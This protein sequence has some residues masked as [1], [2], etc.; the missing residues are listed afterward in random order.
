MP[1]YFS[2]ISSHQTQGN[3]MEDLKSQ[4]PIV[5]EQPL[6]WNDMDSYQHI[7]NTVYFR[8]FEDAR[9]AYFE[10]IGVNEYK[11]QHEVGP[12]LASTRCDFR[13]PL[14]FPDTIRITATVSEIKEKRFTMHYQVFSLKHEAL[15]AKGEGLVVF[16][17]YDKGSSCPIPE[18][19]VARIQG[20]QAPF[21]KG[22]QGA[23]D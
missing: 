8:Y 15:A 1:E 22:E 12:I 2:F 14:E 7:N 6:I 5:L 13:L 3:R 20:L 16:Y 10:E 18:Q 17:D 11:K 19:I 9:I 23:G 21:S 4:F